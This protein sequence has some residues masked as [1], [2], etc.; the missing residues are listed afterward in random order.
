MVRNGL[1]LLLETN[2][3]FKVIGEAANGKEAYRLVQELQPNI[4]IMDIIMDGLDGIDAAKAITNSGFNNIIMLSVHAA[5]C[6]VSEAVQAGVRAYVLKQSTFTDLVR[7]IERVLSGKKY[8]SPQV[9]ELA[10][11][12][13]QEAEV[14]ALT[15]INHLTSRE[16]DVFYLLAQG[17]T[18][19][20]IAQELYVSR[21]T[22][23]THRNQIMR[24]LGL[25]RTVDLVFYALRHDIS[26]DPTFSY[27]G[28]HG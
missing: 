19:A 20:E 15:P 26:Y 14:I 3:G 24:K 6:Y 4:L 2:A 23:E 22:I 25:H 13:E 28:E 5:R 12:C 11:S 10:K 7:A 8:F 21:R 27:S 9:A 16:K 18:N 1:K 17:F